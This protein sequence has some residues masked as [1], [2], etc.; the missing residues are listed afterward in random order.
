MGYTHYWTIKKEDTNLFKAASHLFKEILNSIPS[1][2][3][4]I[5]RGGL[6]EGEPVITDTEIWFNGS[7]KDSHETCHL[8]PHDIEF[9]FCKTARK[10]YSSI[11]ALCLLC[12]DFVYDNDF[13]YSSDGVM[14]EHEKEPIDKDWA[15][16]RKW[17]VNYLSK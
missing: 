14:N 11:V 13:E 1:E 15:L 9:N 4:P 12:F 16:A 10:P 5:L 7:G 2:E 8:N 3:M 17:F 6:G